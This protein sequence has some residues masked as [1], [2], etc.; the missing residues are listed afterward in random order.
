MNLYDDINYW[1]SKCAS[2]QQEVD[3]LNEK[4]A[5]ASVIKW[6][7]GEPK[8]SDEY[9]VTDVNGLINITSFAVGYK[10]D[11]EKFKY[12]IKAWCKLSD[13]VEPYKG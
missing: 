3:V 8:E 9:L 4:L 7:T 11:E 6:Q 12:G 1:I 13:I 2:L 10:P 5:N